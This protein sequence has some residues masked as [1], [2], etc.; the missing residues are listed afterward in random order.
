MGRCGELLLYQ[1]IFLTIN[2]EGQ[3]FC[4]SVSVQKVSPIV[5]VHGFFSTSIFEDIL[6]FIVLE[7][8]FPEIEQ[9]YMS[10][11]QNEALFGILNREDNFAILPTGHG[12]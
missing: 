8:R 10:E 5:I 3:G 6:S 9:L 7:N 2:R 1:R 12:K 11:P 4:C